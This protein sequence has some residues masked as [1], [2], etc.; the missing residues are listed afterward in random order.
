MSTPHFTGF[1]AKA[2]DGGDITWIVGTVVAVPLYYF[3]D[4]ARLTRQRVLS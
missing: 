4:R 2:L 1:I 3:L